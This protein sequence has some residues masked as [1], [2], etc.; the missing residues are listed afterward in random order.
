M[1]YAGTVLL[2]L[3]LAYG[4]VP[5]VIPDGVDPYTI[6]WDI[7]A[8]YSMSCASWFIS[9]TISAIM[10]RCCAMFIGALQPCSP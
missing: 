4:F 9:L 2:F 7:P 6:S 5:E 3:V 10:A 1:Y 8:A